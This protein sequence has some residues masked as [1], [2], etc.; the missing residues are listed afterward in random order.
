MRIYFPKEVD[1]SQG[2]YNQ[3]PKKNSRS[4][5]IPIPITTKDNTYSEEIHTM[6][7]RNTET[8]L[9]F[10]SVA[11]EGKVYFN[12]TDRLPVTYRKG[13]K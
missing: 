13:K 8:R 6:V 5:L 1:T 2:H 4:M 7:T 9:V 11:D 12:Q 3:I 10:E